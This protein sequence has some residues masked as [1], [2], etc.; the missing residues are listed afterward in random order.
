MLLYM[1]RPNLQRQVYVTENDITLGA[2]VEKD[3]KQRTFNLKLE[4][5]LH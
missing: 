2:E 4:M 5:Y 3:L 1:D